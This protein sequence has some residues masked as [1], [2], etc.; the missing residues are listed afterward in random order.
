METPKNAYD[1]SFRE[2]FV[3]GRDITDDDLRVCA[4]VFNSSYGQWSE[5]AKL[6]NPKLEAGQY[7]Y[8]QY[9]KTFFTS[10]LIFEKGSSI[11]MSV[12][13]LRKQCVFDPENCYLA[14]VYAGHDLCGY[15][16]AGIYV[17]SF[18]RLQTLIE[19]TNPFPVSWTCKDQG[20]VCWVTQLV[21]N[22][23]YRCL[24]V[25]TRNLLQLRSSKFTM[26][27]LVSSHIAAC[28]TLA[29]C[30]GSEQ[31]FFVCLLFGPTNHFRTIALPIDKLDLDFIKQNAKNI[32]E[33]TPIQYLKTSVLH[34]SLFS[35]VNDGSI[36]SVNTNFFVDHEKVLGYLR[37]YEE[38]GRYWPLGEL[39]EGHE[40]FIVVRS[41]PN[42][43]E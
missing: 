13:L 39:M 20:D 41:K 42:Y 43:E 14:R 31:L 35:D 8:F 33:T 12:K 29:K 27:G 1:L 37:K 22:T 32:I 26:Y 16:F 30:C 40:Y 3:L 19:Y 10:T 18:I 34:G 38:L 4:E 6:V 9:K 21:T 17:I 28:I 23:K 11:K 25:A 36:S 24:G 5:Q 7:I 15:A 2:K